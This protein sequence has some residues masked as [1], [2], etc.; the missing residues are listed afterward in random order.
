[1]GDVVEEHQPRPHRTLEVHDIQA[2]GGLI[3]AVTIAAG[4]KA[5]EAGNED[6]SVALCETTRTFSPG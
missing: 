5:E 4:V 3:E 2:G 1:M 6:R